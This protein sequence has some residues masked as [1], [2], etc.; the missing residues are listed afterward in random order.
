[1]KM[2]DAIQQ[3]PGAVG[4][5]VVENQPGGF[6]KFARYKV[7]VKRDE[8]SITIAFGVN[9]GGRYRYAYTF[10]RAPFLATGDF[11]FSVSHKGA[12]S[13]LVK[14]IQTGDADFD[15]TFALSGSDEAK[16]QELF[17]DA[18]IRE[19]LS[20]NPSFNIWIPKNGSDG[21]DYMALSSKRPP[22][23]VWTLAMYK[24]YAAPLLISGWDEDLS[25]FQAACDLFSETLGQLVK[26]GCASNANPNFEF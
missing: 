22:S 23:G 7:L 14:H 26:I 10:I 16:A 5:T 6:M 20:A 17:S 8:W 1:M 21:D 13:G 18:R 24:T 25:F 11:N 12:L 2:E 3:L 9:S 15:K 4:G 19:L